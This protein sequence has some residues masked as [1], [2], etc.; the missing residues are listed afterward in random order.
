MNIIISNFDALPGINPCVAI[1]QVAVVDALPGF[2][3]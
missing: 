3:G 1:D 2:C